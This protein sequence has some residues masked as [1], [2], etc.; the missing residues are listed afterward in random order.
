MRARTFAMLNFN[1]EIRR[2]TLAECAVPGE[3]EAMRTDA[4]DGAHQVE[5]V[6]RWRAE[7]GRFHT[8]VYIPTRGTALGRSE[9]VSAL[10]RK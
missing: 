6:A 4:L 1:N 8:L 7:V 9:P 2:L 10:A 5:A 3:F